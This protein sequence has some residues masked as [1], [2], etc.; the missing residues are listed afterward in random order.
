MNAVVTLQCPVDVGLWPV[1]LTLQEGGVSLHTID[2]LYWHEV[3]IW[4][5]SHHSSNSSSVDIKRKKST[6]TNKTQQKHLLCVQRHADRTTGLYFHQMATR[7]NPEILQH[8][9]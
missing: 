9:E 1:C 7:I 6:F 2:L 3:H 4:R 8:L 5:Y